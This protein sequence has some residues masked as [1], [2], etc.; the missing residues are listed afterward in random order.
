MRLRI[1]VISA[2]V[3]VFLTGSVVPAA[4][5]YQA[6]S[7]YSLSRLNALYQQFF[8]YRPKPA[9]APAPAPSPAPSPTTPPAPA[10]APAPS[11]APAPDPNAPLTAEEQQMVS[12]VN[13]ERTSRGLQ[14]LQVDARLVK[15][16]RM[17]S[18]DMIK[19]NYFSHT[20]PVYGSPYDMMKA[21]G[22]TYRKAGE[23]IAGAGTVAKAHTG[24]MNSAGH[25]ANIL[26]PAYTRIGIGIV[27]GGRYGY[28]F[29]QQFIGL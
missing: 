4:A 13:Q 5:A 15:T 28:M 19:N 1:M 25:R 6:P 12:L 11:P 14:P 10:P 18:A 2:L 7:A 8:G 21:A 22:I 20:S 3:L 9:P 23:N 29:T 17:K 24:L 16:A 27:K 26:D